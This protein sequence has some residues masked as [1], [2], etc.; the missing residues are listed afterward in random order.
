MNVILSFREIE[1]SGNA[2]KLKAKMKT[3]VEPGHEFI[4]AN[5]TVQ[6]QT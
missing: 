5:R 1:S 2:G 3:G 6:P 4:H